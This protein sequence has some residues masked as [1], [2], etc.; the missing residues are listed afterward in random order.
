MKT[1]IL[2]RYCT[3]ITLVVLSGLSLIS[4]TAVA[5]LRVLV[6]YDAY[7][8]RLMRVVERKAKPQAPQSLHLKT[9]PAAQENN[10]GQ[11]HEHA[12]TSITLL[13]YAADGSLI[14][15]QSMGD[16]RLTH[17]PLEATGQAPTVIGLDSGAYVVS[18]PSQSA[19]L[20]IQLPQN[21]I[22][23]LDAQ[24]WRLELTR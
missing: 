24:S 3:L 10:N 6:E 16:P 15:S 11:G 19:V 14:E 4:S 22:L 20:E 5:E 1:T 9:A 2:K 8:H 13:W 18:G 12:H 23:G 7:G 17:A 21:D